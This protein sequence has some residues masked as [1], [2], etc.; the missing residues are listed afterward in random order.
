M[1]KYCRNQPG[2]LGFLLLNEDGAVISSDGDLQN[3][4]KTADIIMSLLTLCQHSDIFPGSSD[5]QFKRLSLTY[6]NH[7]Y[8]IAMSNRKIYIVKLQ[9]GVKSAEDIVSGEIPGGSHFPSH[10]D[11]SL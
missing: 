9:F 7:A 8:I 11:D 4:E 3:D 5:E 2:Q 1:E 6:D 10:D